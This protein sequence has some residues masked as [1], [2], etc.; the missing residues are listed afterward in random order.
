MHDNMKTTMASKE[1]IEKAHQKASL[2]FIGSKLYC[3]NVSLGRKGDTPLIWMPRG[4][5]GISVKGQLTPVSAIGLHY[6]NVP[7][8]ISS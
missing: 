7:T 8:G 2:A 1:R 5:M 4:L 3:V 6:V